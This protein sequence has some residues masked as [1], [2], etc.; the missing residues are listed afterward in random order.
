M[1]LKKLDAVPPKE[2]QLVNL[3]NQELYKNYRESHIADDGKHPDA[4]AITELIKN[5]IEDKTY[6]VYHGGGY[7]PDETPVK[8]YD[9]VVYFTWGCDPY[10][11]VCLDNSDG[12]ACELYRSNSD[13][14]FEKTLL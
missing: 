13:A 7:Y 14:K 11:M 2:N 1:P 3:E 10:F 8:V 12:D 5:A 6:K 9:V 4:A